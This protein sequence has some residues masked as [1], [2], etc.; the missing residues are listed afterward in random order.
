MRILTPTPCQNCGPPIERRSCAGARAYLGPADHS[1]SR[2]LRVHVCAA[3]HLIRPSVRL[4]TT[5]PRPRA[6]AAMTIRIYPREKA[7]SIY[8]KAELGVQLDRNTTLIALP[9]SSQ[10]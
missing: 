1:K 4:S 6:A 3:T 9:K 2:V 10:R 8:R 7:A 5:V